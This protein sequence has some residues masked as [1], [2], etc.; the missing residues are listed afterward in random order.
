MPTNLFGVNDNFHPEQSHVIPGLINKFY[1]AVRTGEKSV[2]V[3]GDGSPL[4]E[5]MC[6]DDLA[7]SVLFLSEKV[8]RDDLNKKVSG[9]NNCFSHINVGSEY[10]I[11]IG[12][13]AKKIGDLFGFEGQINFDTTKPNGTP[14]KLMDSSFFKSLGY[15]SQNNFDSDLK[16]TIE[17]FK[18]KVNS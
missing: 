14:R 4:R 9:H 13:L 18:Q 16:M 1:H 12:N 10:E 7:Q 17:W 3:W 15:K 6:S 11:S 2:T 8:E 5:F